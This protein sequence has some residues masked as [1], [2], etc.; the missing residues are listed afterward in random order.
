MILTASTRPGRVGPAVA[1]WFLAAAQKHGK[2]DPRPVD[3]AEVNLPL[4]D[5]PHHPRLQKYQHEH[6]KRWSALVA[7]ADAFALVVPEYNFGPTPALVNALNYLYNEWTYKPA[8]FVSYGGISGGLRAVQQ[9][10]LTLTAL[11]VMPIV[12]AVSIH[13]VHQHLTGD[14][15]KQTF[16]ATEQ[17]EKNAAAMLDELH[18]WAVALRPMRNG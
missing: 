7:A 10:K 4:F 8:A 11:K 13:S 1:R 15:G 2:F 18:K 17:H 16:A 12:E 3:L 5:E 6:T 9:T 14:V